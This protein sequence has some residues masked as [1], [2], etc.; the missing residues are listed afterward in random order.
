MLKLTYY[1]TTLLLLSVSLHTPLDGAAH[2]RRSTPPS[3]HTSTLPKGIKNAYI[4]LS[5]VTILLLLSTGYYRNKKLK[6][7]A[8][9]DKMSK[10]NTSFKKEKIESN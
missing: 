7:I 5:T 2:P 9:K 10:L 3:D 8:E 6:N 1:L 4:A